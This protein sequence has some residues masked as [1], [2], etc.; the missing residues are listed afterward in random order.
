MQQIKTRK[1]VH[2]FAPKILYAGI[3]QINKLIAKENLIIFNRIATRNKLHFGLCYGTLLGAIRDNDFIDHDEDIDLFVLN[4]NKDCFFDCIED[5]INEG[6]EICRYDRR[7]EL[8]SLMR[9]SE[10][11]DIYFFVKINNEL[12]ATLGDPL[13]EKYLTDL[14]KIKFQG[15][16]FWGAKDASEM[17]LFLYGPD[18]E[19][20][21]QTFNYNI[22]LGKYLEIFKWKIYNWIPNIFF[23][24]F[25]YFRN[26]RK[27]ARYE[28]RINRLSLYLNKVNH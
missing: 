23:P 25:V 11:I 18:W 15:E 10:Y 19:T 6:F 13:P 14:V 12:R 7:K 5:L 22:G 28:F 24:L 21:I 1:G 20:P 8:I 26:K 3:K 16:Y 4:E 9:K 17:L 2:L 27:M